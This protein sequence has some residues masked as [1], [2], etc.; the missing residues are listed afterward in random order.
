MKRSI[1]SRATTKLDLP[2]LADGTATVAHGSQTGLSFLL[3]NLF[4]PPIY[5]HF[6]GMDRR[7]VE[8]KECTLLCT[9]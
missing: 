7:D 9:A 5:P 3:K 1:C 8:E 4:K 2:D 6:S